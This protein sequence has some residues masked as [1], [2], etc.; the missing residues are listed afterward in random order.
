MINFELNA[1]WLSKVH[2]LYLQPLGRHLCLAVVKGE[3]EEVEVVKIEEDDLVQVVEEIKIDYLEGKRGKRWLQDGKLLEG[4]SPNVA[5]ELGPLLVQA[6]IRN[7]SSGVEDALDNMYINDTINRSD[8]IA[9]RKLMISL[10][11]FIFELA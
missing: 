1:D 4:L 6:M 11:E 2:N 8:L 5:K 9:L 3:G 7:D 10:S